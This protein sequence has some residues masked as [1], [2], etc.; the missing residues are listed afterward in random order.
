MKKMV[1]M[2]MIDPRTNFA[3][4][5]SWEILLRMSLRQL[6]KISPSSFILEA[7]RVIFL[8]LVSKIVLFVNDL[9]IAISSVIIIYP[10]KN[11]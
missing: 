10:S 5:F 2:M 9:I 1:K 4:I 7:R 8:P 6:L 11:M 3:S